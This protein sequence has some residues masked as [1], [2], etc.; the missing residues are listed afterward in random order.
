[1]GFGHKVSK[2]VSAV[3]YRFDQPLAPRG[4]HKKKV[5]WFGKFMVMS[6]TLGL[7]GFALGMRESLIDSINTQYSQ[8][9]VQ[10]SSTDTP[11]P[12]TATPKLAT[13][14]VDL[15]PTLNKWVYGHQ[16]QRWSIVAKSIE[17]PQFDVSINADQ[18]YES[19]SIYK[20]FLTLPINRQ[21]P[22][23]QQSQTKID[24]GGTKQ[25]IAKC[26]DLMIRI[27]D[28]ACGEALGYYIN[29]GKATTQL[30][31]AGFRQTDFVHHKDTL[32][33]SAADT[34]RFLEQLNGTLLPADARDAILTSMSKQVFRDGIPAGCPGCTVY[35]KIGNIDN[36]LHDAGIVSYSRGKYILVIFSENS[37]DYKAIAEVA[38]QV[39]QK[40]LDTI[41]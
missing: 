41:K 23:K 11:A 7:F 31:E 28:N 22:F 9:A 33:T 5:G 19:A 13:N 17:G 24:I 8:T 20:L 30:Q 35:D 34:A 1:M 32:E 25:T 6:M 38:G 2:H 12:V 15:Q 4:W 14:I 40:I 16:N 36:V 27:S 21:I 39:H 10:T 26:V 3:E 29:W 18:L 37:R